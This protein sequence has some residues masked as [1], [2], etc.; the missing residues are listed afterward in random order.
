[1]TDAADEMANDVKIPGRGRTVAAIPPTKRT[2]GT[3]SRTSSPPPRTSNPIDERSQKREEISNAAEDYAR[4]I[5]RDLN[6]F[7]VD[8]AT[9]V[10]TFPTNIFLDA[11][12]KLT[13]PAGEM[14]AFNERERK[15]MGQAV[16]RLEKTPTGAVVIGLF[17][18]WALPVIF[19]VGALVIVG[20]K[21]VGM[22][23]LRSHAMAQRQAAAQAQ[24][25]QAQQ[26]T[27]AKGTTTEEANVA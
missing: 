11:E 1:M 23:G 17:E 19:G 3:S 4:M 16:A 18:D 21:A 22:I 9:S 13:K 27:V 7:M 24:Q 5:E 15:M 20:V 12:G 6:P 10:T 14:V 2:N 26:D 25:T 8:I